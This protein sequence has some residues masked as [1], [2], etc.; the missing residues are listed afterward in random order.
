MNLPLVIIEGPTAIGKSDIAVRLAKLTDGEIVSA[1]SMQVYRGMDIGTG[2]IRPDECMGIPHYMLD[3]AD[4][5]EEYD[6]ARYKED[7]KKAV[8][9]I[10]HR[11]K[12]PI[13]CGGTGFYIQAVVK[14]IDFSRGVPDA[15]YRRMLEDA[16]NEKGPEYIYAMLLEK[17]PDAALMIHPNNVKKVIRALEYYRDTGEKISVKN[18][19]DKESRSPYDYLEFLIDGDRGSLYERIDK[20]VDQMIA[21]GLVEEVK[22]LMEKGAGRHM[23]SMQALGYKEMIDHITGKTDF[24]EAVRIL[25]RD[26]RHYAKRQ[27]TWFNHQGDPVRIMREDFEN[28]N[29]KIA[30]YI[31]KK[32][33]EHYYGG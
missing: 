22:G 14:D 6:I 17:D 32:V 21:D 26:T 13:L 33:K 24:E 18:R 27:L 9:D 4:P 19:R 10:A 29:E 23:V 2:K 20:R 28:D 1:D 12:I 11:G 30:E 16:A 31:A 3:V 8:L 25:K 7:A 15:D 5:C